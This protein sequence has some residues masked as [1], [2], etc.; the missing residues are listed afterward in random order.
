MKKPPPRIV[1]IDDDDAVRDAVCHL[2][3]SVGMTATVQLATL[4]FEMKG[5][6]LG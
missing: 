1:V 4:T 3:T 6:L 5:Q 2:V